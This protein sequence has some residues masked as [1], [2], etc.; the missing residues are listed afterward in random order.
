MNRSASCRQQQSLQERGPRTKQCNRARAILRLMVYLADE[1]RLI[2]SLASARHIELAI[3]ELSRSHQS[4][5]EGLF[6]GSRD[7]DSPTGIPETSGATFLMTN[8]SFRQLRAL[9][10][11]SWKPTTP[12]A[13]DHFVERSGQFSGI[14]SCHLALAGDRQTVRPGAPGS[15]A[16]P[17]CAGSAPNR[18]RIGS[19]SIPSRLSR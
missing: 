11:D 17:R 18:R 13:R 1:A 3:A 7:G 16:D 12:T 6:D 19:G 9:R 15:T 14:V 4:A 5:E 8:N 10:P 2:G